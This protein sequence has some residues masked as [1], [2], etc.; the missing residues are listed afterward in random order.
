MD[1]QRFDHVTRMIAAGASRRSVLKGLTGALLGVAAGA[2]WRSHAS[3]GECGAEGDACGGD[4]NPL[5]C[6]DLECSSGT[7]TC[8]PVVAPGCE[9]DDDCAEGEFCGKGQ[10]FALPCETVEDCPEGY[11]CKGVCFPI[12][13]ECEVDED[14]VQV[15]G[16]IGP[17]PICC[18]GTCVAQECCGADDVH[19]DEGE[20]CTD[21]GICVVIGPECET[22][23][24]CDDGEICCAEACHAIECCIEDEDP[25][26]RC[27]DGETCF[28]GVCEAVCT[29]D[30]DCADDACCCQ[31]G[32]C[33]EDCCPDPVEPV[34]E[35]P[36]T[37]VADGDGGMSGLMTAGLAVGAAALLAGTKLRASEDA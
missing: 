37:G 10:C 14:C 22:D 20:F 19:C 26:A 2:G 15:E 9:T 29:G 3:A 11:F 35:L 17:G 23:E 5:C 13:P 21:E 6:G 18:A 32:S 30:A 31:D 25:N 1:G 36:S 33:S 16:V 7:E 27:G 24:D 4:G 12:P 8:Q 28:E 34:V